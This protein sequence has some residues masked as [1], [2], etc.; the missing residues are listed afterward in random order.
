LLAETPEVD[1]VAVADPVEQAREQAATAGRTQ[2]VA[3]FRELFG[4]I[5]AAVVA[6]PTRLHR[7]V[8]MRLVEQGIHVLVEKP[9]TSTTA[10]ADELIAAARR[11][12]VVLQVGHVERFNPVWKS[13]AGHFGE[14]RFIEA[15]RCG[16]YTFRSTD[17][18]VVLDLMVHDIDLVLSLVSSSVSR[19]DAV[20][21]AVVGPHEDVAN[22]RVS[23]ANGAVANLNASRVSYQAERRMRIYSPTGFASV[24]FATRTATV[25]SPSARIAAGEIDPATISAEDREQVMQHFIA[26]VL[27]M[28][29]LPAME[30]NAIGEELLDF[31]AAIRE[32]RAPRV[33]GEDGRAALAVCEEIGR[34]IAAQASDER[35]AAT[36]LHPATRHGDSRR[37]AG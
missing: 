14:P 16:P 5:D 22:A 23:F 34:Q 13:A 24:D 25:V 4:K 9:I 28:R 36:L 37:A 26:E 31:V 6:T 2:A 27:P 29:T 12:G 21:R 7:S 20:G 11:A 35:K 33:T 15:T 1:L 18:G 3:D 19:V 17:V 8:G 32:S 30:G 10:E